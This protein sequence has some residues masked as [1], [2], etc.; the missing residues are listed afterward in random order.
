VRL[1]VKEEKLKDAAHFLH[2]FLNCLIILV[3][4]L[5]FTTSFS[6]CYIFR[7]FQS[8]NYY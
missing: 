1:A 5:F 2:P 3:K 4:S 7:E 8:D 6:L